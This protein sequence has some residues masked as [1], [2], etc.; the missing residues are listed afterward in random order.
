MMT[1]KDYCALH[2]IFLRTFSSLVCVYFFQK[3]DNVTVFNVY[4]SLH[5]IDLK[6]VLFVY[7]Q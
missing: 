6:L 1:G 3:N 5:G 4:C 7:R 2:Y